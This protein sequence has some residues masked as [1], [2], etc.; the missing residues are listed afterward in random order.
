MHT[1]LV[2]SKSSLQIYSLAKAQHNPAFSFARKSP[3]TGSSI[4][5]QLIG[6]PCL[7]FH[8]EK[9]TADYFRISQSYNAR[10]TRQCF[11]FK[12]KLFSLKAQLLDCSFFFL[13]CLC[14]GEEAQKL[15]CK[16]WLKAELSCQGY[17]KFNLL[18]IFWGD[19]LSQALS[20]ARAACQLLGSLAGKRVE[21]PGALHVSTRVCCKSQPPV[22]KPSALLNILMV[23]LCDCWC[24]YQLNWGGS[25]SLL[26]ILFWMSCFSLEVMLASVTAR[27][28]SSWSL[29][30][31][32]TKLCPGP[33]LFAGSERMTKAL[34]F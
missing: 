19:V 14:I 8:T 3:V 7:S 34:L 18:A 16:A 12:R 15:I 29:E 20:G 1:F 10:V 6:E 22:I 4:Q 26:P 30:D 28:F 32:A 31:W 33:Q 21:K 9:H 13:P 27:S 23:V 24:V 25:G 2:L 5:L 17:S 11:F